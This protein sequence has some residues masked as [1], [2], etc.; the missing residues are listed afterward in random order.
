MENFRDHSL[1]EK[2]RSLLLSAFKVTKKFPKNEQISI[3]NQIQ[4]CCVEN[5]ANI[6]RGSNNDE[7]EHLF[8]T[9]LNSINK[10]E[11]YLQNA[12]DMHVLDNGDF[13]L[14]IKEA[15]E[16]KSLLSSSNNK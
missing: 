10:L 5:L 14:L 9:S 6:I 15:A 1:W 4:N 12:K 11:N 3:G 16:I 13:K 2:S 8:R 7:I